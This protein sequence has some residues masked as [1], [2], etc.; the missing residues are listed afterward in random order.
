LTITFVEHQV[1]VGTAGNDIDAPVAID[2]AN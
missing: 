1:S 2:I